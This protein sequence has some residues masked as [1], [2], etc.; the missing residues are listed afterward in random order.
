[1]LASVELGPASKRILITAGKRVLSQ[2][3][4]LEQ[5]IQYV[6]SHKQPETGRDLN[7]TVTYNFLIFYL[8]AL[9]DVVTWRQ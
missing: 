5:N 8:S 2:Q 4:Q 9:P 1:M 6:L 3:S 7:I